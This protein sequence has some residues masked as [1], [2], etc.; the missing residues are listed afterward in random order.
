MTD[1]AAPTPPAAR[2]HANV[3]TPWSTGARTLIWGFVLSGVAVA[4]LL[5]GANPNPDDPSATQPSTV[6]GVIVGA[7]GFPLLLLGLIA[8]GVR[9]GL[10]DRDGR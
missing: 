2:A 3:A 7:V 6:V 4:L 8:V 1:A 9:I 10:D 5:I